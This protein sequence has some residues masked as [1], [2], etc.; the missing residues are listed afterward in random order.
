MNDYEIK[1][2]KAEREATVI[3]IIGMVVIVAAISTALFYG[4]RYSCSARWSGAYE[5]EYSLTAGC[6]VNVDGKLFPEERVRAVQ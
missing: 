5:T 1:A 4:A 2:K 6:R 3:A